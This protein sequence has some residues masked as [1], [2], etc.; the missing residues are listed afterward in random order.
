[1]QPLDK[2]S[3][4]YENN[5]SGF[6]SCL[7]FLDT[8][9]IKEVFPSIIIISCTPG[10]EVSCEK[11]VPKTPH[12]LLNFLAKQVCMQIGCQPNSKLFLASSDREQGE[13]FWPPAHKE[14]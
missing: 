1:M 2:V 4:I 14:R 13:I 10:P 3:T 5:K 9:T 11:I 6:Q 8:R 12:S 7:L